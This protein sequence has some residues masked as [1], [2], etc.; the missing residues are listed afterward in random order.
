[1]QK[2]MIFSFKKNNFTQFSSVYGFMVDISSMIESRRASLDSQLSEAES[3]RKVRG[4]KRSKNHRMSRG[5]NSA[6]IAAFN[7]KR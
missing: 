6:D 4:R 7:A 2:Q 1:M 5:V 3:I